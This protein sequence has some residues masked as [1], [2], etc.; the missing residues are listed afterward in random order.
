MYQPIVVILQ[1]LGVLLMVAISYRM[2]KLEQ[3]VKRFSSL[4]CLKLKGEIRE[5]HEQ[6]GHDAEQDVDVME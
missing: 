6:L 3:H 5:L 2:M 4:I 1:C